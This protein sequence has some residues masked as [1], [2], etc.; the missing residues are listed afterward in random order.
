M[1]FAPALPSVVGS[2][3]WHAQL[4][5]DFA[6]RDG[7]TELVRQQHHGPLL[8][9]RTFHPEAAGTAHVYLLHPPGGM[10]AGDVLA[11]RITLAP[12]SRTLLTTPAAGKTY[13]RGP[14]GPVHL[15]Q[16]LEVADGA[17]LELLPQESILYDGAALVAGQQ[18]RLTGAAAYIGWEM[19][20]FGRPASGERFTRGSLRQHWHLERE[21]MPLWI[22]RLH[23]EPEAMDAAW[24]LDGQ[25]CLGTFVACPAPADADVIARS[26]LPDLPTLGVTQMG[27]VLIARYL[28]PDMHQLKALFLQLWQALRPHIT[29]TPAVP[30]RVWAT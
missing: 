8:V 25:P 21:G 10:V 5:L 29:G 7:R 19:I 14:G 22:E 18:V 11:V 24:G 9:Q 16:Q 15:D 28:G 13:R 30:P 17:I 6:C 20:S 2:T 1:T 27:E 4:A 23:L 12:G 3:G 26:A